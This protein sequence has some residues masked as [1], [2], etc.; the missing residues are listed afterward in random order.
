MMG[1]SALPESGCVA[2][3][4]ISVLKCDIERGDEVETNE[5]MMGRSGDELIQP[6]IHDLSSSHSSSHRPLLHPY[7]I[8][9]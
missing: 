2:A 5:G 9:S 6:R 7:F 3:Q 1:R 8:P 4:Y